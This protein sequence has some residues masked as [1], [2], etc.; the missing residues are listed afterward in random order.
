MTASILIQIQSLRAVVYKLRDDTSSPLDDE[1]NE[2]IRQI[3]NAI[4][5]LETRVPL[6]N[7]PPDNNSDPMKI[8]H[9]LTSPIS[10][11]I[12]YLYILKQEYTS[13]LSSIQLELVTLIENQTQQVYQLINTHI[14]SQQSNI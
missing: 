9:D 12:G 13:P 10:G 4:D 8:L 7:K 11:I 14:L 6:L 5:L 2:E 3:L 1:Q